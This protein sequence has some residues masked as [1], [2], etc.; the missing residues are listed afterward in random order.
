MK[1]PKKSIKKVLFFSPARSD[2]G[3]ISNL[4]SLFKQDKSIEC[5]LIV[6]GSHLD[7]DFGNTKDEIPASIYDKKY[8]IKTRNLGS[9]ATNSLIDG[10]SSM[11]LEVGQILFN[12][13]PDLFIVLGDRQEI[14]PACYCALLNRIPIAH[15]GGGDTTLGAID[16]EIRH[17][18]SQ[19]SDYHFVTSQASES[20]LIGMNIP[21]E[22]IFYTGSPSDSKLIAM[23]KEKVSRKNLLK[24]LGITED[25]KIILCTFH[26]E[27]KNDKSFNELRVFTQAL[28][29][30]PSDE[31]IFIFTASNG[32]KEGFKFNKFIRKQVLATSNFYFFESLGIDLYLR[33]MKCSV[34]VAGNSSSGL[35]EAPSLKV[36]T[37]DVGN[38]QQG[39][40][41]GDSVLNVKPN[42]SAIIKGIRKLIDSKEDCNFHN[43]YIKGSDSSKE[44]YKTLK[45][46]LNKS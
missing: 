40:L 34:L 19:L 41:R 29:S 15:I 12:I 24:E 27:T 22:D 4:I 2:F 18:V 31:F 39:R 28:E 9:E 1:K 7:K 35:H 37:L 11:M 38:R 10:M 6:T 36:P 14:L 45:R 33:T 5:S 16:N 20:T 32:D 44:I 26:P 13:K 30:L 8:E 21:K 42:K 46:K 23:G 43:P 17:S 25:R 3:I